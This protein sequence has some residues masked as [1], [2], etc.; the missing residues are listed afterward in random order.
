MPA[1]GVSSAFHGVLPSIVPCSLKT[2]APEGS[3]EIVHFTRGTGGGEGVTGSEFT[4]VTTIGFVG[5]GVP[6]RKV[7]TTATSSASAEPVIK[8]IRRL[9]VVF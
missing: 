4:G 3:L 2:A 9:R 1:L 8:N 5:G 6:T 7:M